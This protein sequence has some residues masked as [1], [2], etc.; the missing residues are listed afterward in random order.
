MQ[1]GTLLRCAHIEER[2][3][4]FFNE[5]G[6]NCIQIAGV[7]EEYLAPTDEARKKSDAIFELFRK[8]KDKKE[9][10]LNEEKRWKE[11]QDEKQV[12]EEAD[13]LYRE[14]SGTKE[15]DEKKQFDPELNEAVN[16]AA[17]LV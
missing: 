17:D 10:S 5:I 3:I 7:F 15:K 14:N 4:A 16:I 13:R 9:V 8:Y 12:Q 6:I 1:I 11:Y 2:R